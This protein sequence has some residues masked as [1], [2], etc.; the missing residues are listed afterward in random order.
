MKLLGRALLL[1]LIA[2]WRIAAAEGP[3]QPSLS[4]QVGAENVRLDWK[5]NLY[6]LDGPLGL[7]A[8][9]DG[10]ITWPEIEHRRQD[11]ESY[12]SS[13]LALSANGTA[14]E[15]SFTKLMYGDQ[16]GVPYLLAQL[17]AN[18]N[19]IPKSIG[20]EYSLASRRSAED[21][22]LLTV[23]WPEG[24]IEKRQITPAAGHSWTFAASAAHS[25]FAESLIQGVWH[26]WT[27]Y[28][29][30]LFL[31]V[32]LIPAVFQRT[33][34]GREA[35]P[36]FREAL[37]RVVII[38]SAFTIAHSIT[39]TC[40]A[41]QWLRLPSRL[42]ESV[43]AASIVVAAANNLLPRSAGGRSA[44]LASGFGLIHGFGFAGAL[45]ESGANGGQPLWQTI[46]AFNLG[47]ECGQLAI[48]SV[49]LPIA[50]VLRE[51]RFYRRGVLYVGSSI[52]G[53]LALIWLYQRALG[54]AA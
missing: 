45:S 3:S 23:I 33:A 12:L 8:D 44:W 22:C 46:L 54:G 24:R 1:L 52:A 5:V 37:F 51:T 9:H 50:Y 40:A 14:L 18:S 13:H 21:E 53:V 49:F 34:T 17:S 20:I 43:I 2:C 35:V 42:V 31:I 36:T 47:V 29:H 6:D 11:I 10:R 32:L 26:I 7:D 38:V 16:G 25:A 15:L 39:L 48:V 19:D 41:M 4:L 27:G 28:D 30:I